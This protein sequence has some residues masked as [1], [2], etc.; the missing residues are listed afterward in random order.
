[1]T[2]FTRTRRSSDRR[3]TAA[4]GHEERFPPTRLSA[5]YGPDLVELRRQ[6]ADDVARIFRGAS[7]AEL[8]IQG[9]T[10]F[11]FVVNL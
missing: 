7:P 9:P 11:D 2:A 1:M 5:G 6:A 3:W 10:H 4:L 8:P